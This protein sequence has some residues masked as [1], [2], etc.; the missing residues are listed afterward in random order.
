MNYVFHP[1]AESEFFEAINYLEE[2]NEGLGKTFSRE[3]FVAIRKITFFP[4][5]W[6]T[7]SKNARRILVNRFPYGII[8]QVSGEEILIVAVMHS[9]REPNY[10]KGRAK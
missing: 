1:E 4:F 2:Q 7:I 10:W 5:A 6:T 9:S 3:I 8:Y